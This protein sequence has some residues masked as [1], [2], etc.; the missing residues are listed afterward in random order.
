MSSLYFLIYCF[1][2]VYNQC[3]LNK[4]KNMDIFAAEV[5]FNVLRSSKL[6]FKLSTE[7][8]SQNKIITETYYSLPSIKKKY[9]EK[10]C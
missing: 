8:K 10:Y 1:M 9:T 5:C 7:Q 3:D 2:N 4:L 6:I